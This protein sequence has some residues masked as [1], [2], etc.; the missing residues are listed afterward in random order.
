MGAFG[1]CI[2]HIV[3]LKVEYSCNK[4][5]III[6][7]IV[8]LKV[9]Y[10]CNKPTTTVCA[11]KKFKHWIVMNKVLLSIIIN[12]VWEYF[13]ENQVVSARNIEDTLETRYLTNITATYT[14]II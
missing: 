11:P 6:Y 10:S 5:F 13:D 2:Y 9:E 8:L 4:E 7:H 14:S 12:G 3:L 1:C